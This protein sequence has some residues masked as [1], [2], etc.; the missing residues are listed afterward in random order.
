MNRIDN[1]LLGVIDSFCA[2]DLNSVSK[3]LTAA[4][5]NTKLVML[6]KLAKENLDVFPYLEG[7]SITPISKDE[8]L[9]IASV[10]V[11]DIFKRVVA[12]TKP[13][14]S[15]LLNRRST[16]EDVYHLLGSSDTSTIL[17]DIKNELQDD[18]LGIVAGVLRGEPHNLPIP[19]GTP[20]VIRA[21][22]AN[23]NNQQRLLAI[24][25]LDLSRKELKCLPDEFGNL[26][27][28]QILNLDNNQL[29]ALPD[30]IGNLGNLQYLSLNNNQFRALPDSIGNLENLQRLDLYHNQLTALPVSI[31]NL[32]N[33]RVTGL[34]EL[35]INKRCRYTICEN[36]AICVLPVIALLASAYFS[37]RTTDY[38]YGSSE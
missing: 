31:A 1:G 27:N 19:Q 33:L 26:G 23:E 4:D 2:G 24:N 22:F 8:D 38:L 25:E 16:K 21:W 14:A 28:L 30:S 17:N 32:Y 29:T 13:L 34:P 18:S 6:Q 15:I 35:K 3:R 7:L 36:I 10:L 20:A 5:L 11:N 37:P 9:H 12:D